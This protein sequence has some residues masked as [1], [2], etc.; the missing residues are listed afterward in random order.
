[1]LSG[2]PLMLETDTSSALQQLMRLRVTIAKTVSLLS[3]TMAKMEFANYT[4]ATWGRVFDTLDLLFLV[5][6]QIFN[7]IMAVAYMKSPEMLVSIINQ[8]L[9]NPAISGTTA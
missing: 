5:I 9:S 2:R 6:F 7:V 8:T 1:S 4:Q 3:E